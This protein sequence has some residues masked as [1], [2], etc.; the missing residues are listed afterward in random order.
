MW[1]C[2]HQAPCCLHSPAVACA[3]PSDDLHT[4]A[5]ADTCAGLGT[6]AGTLGC[7]LAAARRGLRMLAAAPAVCALGRAPACVQ[8]ARQSPACQEGVEEQ[9]GHVQQINEHISR[10]TSRTSSTEHVLV[11]SRYKEPWQVTI[12][13]QVNPDIQPSAFALIIM[14]LQCAS[15]AVMWC[16]DASGTTTAVQGLP[17]SSVGCAANAHVRFVVCLLACGCCC[18]ACG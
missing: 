10:V 16:L 2:H 15:R 6:L 17:T 7:G 12:L 5:C 14:T 9:P 11:V 4:L 3:G 18:T 13:L 1:A 8:T